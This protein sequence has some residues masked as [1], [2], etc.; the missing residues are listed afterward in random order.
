MF[1]LFVD[2]FVLFENFD[3]SIKIWTVIGRINGGIVLCII[4]S[5]N[6]VDRGTRKPKLFL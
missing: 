5:P 4:V 6:E 1:F 2:V 3:I